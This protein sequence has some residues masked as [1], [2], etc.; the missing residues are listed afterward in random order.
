MNQPFWIVVS[1]ARGPASWP[2]KHT[3]Q[4]TAIAEAT[5]LTREHGGEFYVMEAQIVV[6]KSDVVV[7]RL[8][9]DMEIPF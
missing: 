3:T 8:A 2:C 6:R 1:G 9:D 4:S 7:K 5:R